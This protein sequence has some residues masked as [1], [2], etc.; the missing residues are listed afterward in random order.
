M[1]ANSFR[2]VAETDLE[3]LIARVQRQASFGAAGVFGP[4]S[5]T[6]KINRESALF[7][8][9]GRA[10]LLQLAHPW[11]AAALA[12]HS[13]TLADPIGRFHGTFGVVYSIIFGTLEQAVAASRGLHQ[14]HS[15]IR[16]T[17]PQTA[18][19]FPAGSSYEANEVAALR[20]VYATLIDSAVF[21]YELVLTPLTSQ[22]REAYYHESLLTAALFG[23]SH[24]EL[25]PDWDGFQRYL[26]A[27]FEGGSISV[28][29]IALPIAQQLMVGAG[30]WVRPP[31]WYRAL[32]AWSMPARL[33][34]EFEL[35][36][37]EREWRL[38][39]RARRWLPRFY[40]ALPGWLRFVGPYREAQ[41]RLRGRQPSLP[42]RWSNRFWIGRPSLLAPS[43]GAKFASSRA[44]GGSSA[45]LRSS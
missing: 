35:P 6:W 27:M 3:N 33:R 15:R 10:A 22:E 25:P 21:A 30:S 1:S 42:V 4:S 11:V 23:I 5:I 36:Y 41:Q 40:Q 28:S 39:L 14:L 37:E 20:W 34:H 16:G 17:L 9:A 44:N 26:A 2:P 29:A 45:S 19:V 24:E 18:G 8:A 38:V 7:L 32:T 12:Q 43:S 13:R 31:L